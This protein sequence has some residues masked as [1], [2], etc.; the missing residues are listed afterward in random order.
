MSMPRR[1]GGESIKSSAK[2]QSTERRDQGMAAKEKSQRHFVDIQQFES[3]EN[4]ARQVSQ[5]ATATGIQTV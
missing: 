4:Y 1:F 2:M 5:N 3:L